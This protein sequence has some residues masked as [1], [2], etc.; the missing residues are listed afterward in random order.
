MDTRASR[1]A[2]QAQEQGRTHEQ[3]PPRRRDRHLQGLAR[4][5]RRPRGESMPVPQRQ[6]RPPQADRLD[7]PWGRPDRV[8]THRSLPPRLRGHPPEGRAP[9]VRD[10]PLPSPVLRPLHRAARQD[11]RGGRPNA[12]HDGVGHRGSAS[13]RGEI[14]RTARARRA[15]ADPRRAGQ[16]SHRNHQPGQELAHSRGQAGHQAEAAADRAA[17]QGHRR[18]DPGGGSG[19]RRRWSAG[20][21]S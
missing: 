13:D 16:G 8:R 21:R 10:Q 14:G 17:A 11:R 1:L 19:R 9:P 12:G 15:S 7:R 6:R 18:R 3:H 5:L 4:R 20:P 2:R